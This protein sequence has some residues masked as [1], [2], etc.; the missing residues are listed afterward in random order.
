MLHLFAGLPE[1]VTGPRSP[2]TLRT[3]TAAG[4]RTVFMAL[5]LPF[6]ALSFLPV[7][8][9]PLLYVYPSPL[10]L[11]TPLILSITSPLSDLLFLRNS[12][13]FYVFLT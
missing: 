5:L 13:M 10:S 1:L 11:L 3:G 7:S 8:P 6:N 2:T 4:S 12:R 9:L